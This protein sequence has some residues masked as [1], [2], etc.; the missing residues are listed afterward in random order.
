[1]FERSSSKCAETCAWVRINGSSK[2]RIRYILCRRG[3][4]RVLNSSITFCYITGG[5]SYG[6]FTDEKVRRF[7]DERSTESKKA[8]CSERSDDTVSRELGEKMNK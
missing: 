3:N 2:E 7:P 8:M 6:D 1:M 4:P 5:S